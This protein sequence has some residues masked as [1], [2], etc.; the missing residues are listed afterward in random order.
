MGSIILTSPLHGW[1]T[2][3]DDV[4]DAV[5]SG[6]MLGDGIAIDP[7]AG[8]LHAPCDGEIMILHAS[9]HA[10]TL[11]GEGGVEVLMHLGIDTVALGGKGFDPLV[12]VGDRVAR[13]QP[14][15]RFDLDAVAQSV[16][17]L[18]TPIIITNAESFR[19]QRCVTGQLVGVGEGILYLEPV[20]AAVALVATT[21]GA[22]RATSTL[23][24]P[25]VHGIHAR[26]AARI[27]EAARAFVATSWLVKDGCEASTRSPIGLLQLG[28]RLNDQIDIVATGED[29]AAA[30]A[31][32]RA[33]IESGMDEI[34]GAGHPVAVQP[35]LSGSRILPDGALGGTLAA[36]G[37]C[38]GT[39][40]W[41]R[42]V[43]IDLP[44]DGQGIDVENQRLNDAIHVMR[45]RL[46]QSGGHDAD[47]AIRR[48]HAA[49]LDDPAL[50]HSAFAHVDAGRDAGHAWRHAC[51]D[52]AGT[53][54]A[55]G[56]ARFAER[57][58]DLLDLERQVLH[59]LTGTPDEVPSFP[60]GTILLADELVPSQ[61]MA[62]DTHVVGI[63][64]E[65]GGPT[66]HVAILAASRGLPMLV[67]VGRP[68]F[69]IADGTPLILDA[70]DGLILPDPAP[71]TLAA[72]RAKVVRRSQARA[73]AVA[74][75]AM[76]CVSGDGI[77]IEAFANLG[78]LDDADIAMANGAEGSGLLRT[79]FLFLE[80]DCAPDIAEQAALYGRI[81]ARLDG[82]PLIIRLLDIGG[83]KP[84]SYLPIAAEE[85]PALGLRGIRVGLAMPDIL[86]R[87]LRAILSVVPHGQ[88]RIMVPMVASVSELLAVRQRV[89]ALRR[90]L[91]IDHPVEVGIM[92]ETP[93]AA[94]TAA[95]LARHADFLSIGTND[96]TQYALA[97]DRGNPAVAA[98]V[99]GLHPAVLGLIALTTAGASTH[100]RWV[101]VCGG[102]AS[103]RLAI[104]LLLGL[105]VTELSAAPHFV[106][107]L[108]AL[109]RRLSIAEC[110]RHAEA[111]LQLESADQVRALARR[112]EEGLSQ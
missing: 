34:E 106:P 59:I 94:V 11:R 75:A 108:N 63:A 48:A 14:L 9:C 13:G 112:F 88:C 58:D 28:I 27:G 77:R 45:Q 19:I 38:V 44:R 6:R 46:T 20:E 90:E 4:P 62:L 25:M 49:F 21:D 43:D 74:S 56:D 71:E 3:M 70:D 18:I 8:L 104:P 97:M 7:L 66:S 107:D 81:A 60:P 80:R 57:A 51:R 5:F 86:D 92:V 102:L 101:G 16:P 100:K 83:D 29:A 98:G 42:V 41:L 22:N 31:A 47:A 85:N 105:G 67:A 23:C 64:L 55:M 73:D 39:A 54:R 91:V 50:Q 53:M 26:P 82:R 84:A 95:M 30:V 72:A 37:Y 61:V 76:P 24:V 12:T 15:I 32:I 110:R 10:V 99:D 103:D 78:S 93:A 65:G 68:L 87:Q 96:L 33:L 52:M 111:A 79:E 40:H 36:P 89:D 17:S 35:M 1:T 109:V 69:A 2:V